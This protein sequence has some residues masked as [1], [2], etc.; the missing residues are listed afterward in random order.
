MVSLTFLVSRF[1]FLEMLA[2]IKVSK[3]AAFRD[4]RRPCKN[5]DLEGK[6]AHISRAV[7]EQRALSSLISI[8]SSTTFTTVRNKRVLYARN[9]IPNTEYYQKLKEFKESRE[10]V[11]DQLSPVD[12]R[13]NIPGRVIHLIRF[14]DDT[15]N[16]YLPYYTSR[17]FREIHFC[18]DSMKDHSI[19]N[20]SD[21]LG[22][23]VSEYENTSAN[24]SNDDDD[25]SVMSE[26]S[27]GGDISE[28]PWFVVFSFPRGLVASLIPTFL[29][30]A[31]GKTSMQKYS[32]DFLTTG[33]D[34]NFFLRSMLFC[35]R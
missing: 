26:N 20:L 15:N 13:L 34:H 6:F 5:K 27:F 16:R 1:D 24:V 18:L 11:F 10:R 31:A 30:V 17:K 25:I 23:V 35:D 8:S 12:T 21:V 28:E 29:A 32:C 19:K 7:V 22:K 9:E 4:S 3:I 2:R 14:G 33:V